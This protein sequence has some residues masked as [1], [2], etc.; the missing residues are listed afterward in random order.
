MDTPPITNPKLADLEPRWASFR[1]VSLLFENPTDSPLY[2][3]LQQGAELL[4]ND[5]LVEKYYFRLLPPESLHVT[6]WDGVNDGKLAEV[7]PEFRLA[8]EH[9]LDALPAPHL[10]DSLFREILNS[11]LLTFPDW[12]LCL[13]CEQI[14]NWSNIS[15]VARLGPADS[16]SAE[17]LQRLIQARAVL[18]DVFGRKFGVRPHA[19]Y[20][21]HITLGYF[22]NDGYAAMAS[23]SVARWNAALLERTAGLILPLHRVRLSLY[24]NM[25]GF[26]PVSDDQP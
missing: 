14:E 22:A 13:Q 2:R 12:N 11:E 15:L 4:K 17:S 1:G 26:P 8:W 16:A 7:V 24:Q 18:S 20:T 5:A 3:A 23:S 10:P 25:T 9:F 21:P 6:A 19:V